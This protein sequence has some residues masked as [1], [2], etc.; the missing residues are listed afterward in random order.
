MLALQ[1]KVGPTLGP[2]KQA[3]LACGP[4][5]N[6]RHASIERVH[7]P[8]ERHSKSSKLSG[9]RLEKAA[10]TVG[11]AAINGGKL[12]QQQYFIAAAI[13]AAVVKMQP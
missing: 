9:F 5:V 6:G 13:N 2:R 10:V 8:K 12:L 3:S 11:T 1:A 7:V 4:K